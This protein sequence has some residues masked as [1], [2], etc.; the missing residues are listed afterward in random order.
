[1]LKLHC[2]ETRALGRPTRADDASDRETR[3]SLGIRGVL[4]VSRLKHTPL[5]GRVQSRIKLLP[6]VMVDGADSI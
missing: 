4:L 5:M 3:S 2:L 1:M 6:V